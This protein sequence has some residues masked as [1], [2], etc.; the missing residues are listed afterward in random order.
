V[1]I[2]A[3]S[4]LV[5][6]AGRRGCGVRFVQPRQAA[7]GLYASHMR[8][9]L[10]ADSLFALQERAML[11]RLELGLADDGVSVV[12]ALPEQLLAR[13]ASDVFARS[14]PYTPVS[15]PLLRNFATRSLAERV[16]KLDAD[17]G[18]GQHV[19]V[20]HAFGG[21]IW[22]VA[23]RLAR[24]IGAG[25]ALD[26]WRSGLVSRVREL[27]LQASDDVVLIAPDAKTQQRLR[28]QP[29]AV[30]NLPCVVA[31]WGVLAD[32]PHPVLEA[33]R[34]A[35]IMLVG[36][37]RDS[38]AFHAVIAGLAPMLRQ[39]DDVLVFCDARAARRADLWRYAR[40]IDK[41]LVV[42]SRISLV[43]DLEARPDLLLAGDLLLHPEASGEQRSMLLEAFGRGVVVVAANDPNVDF[44]ISGTTAQL[45][46]QP[47]E[48]GAWAS[49]V[50]ELLSHPA[51][52]A[53]L[54]AT[55]NAYVRTHRKA[56]EQVR[57]VLEAYTK[58]RATQPA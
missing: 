20:V 37:G 15:A 44:L 8:A 17:E 39:R 24:Q 38:A 58:L 35:S 50:G 23:L 7:W 13:S 18:E 19:R 11:S 40:S 36:T 16:A 29:G 47:R 48:P 27:S 56:S 14:L 25:L 1:P 9:L 28:E 55:A 4:E 51:K 21:S 22:P 32:T 31:P 49:A 12:Q 5:G 42:R 41:D 43:E 54:A 52:A 45:V 46:M 33:K 2:I 57:G 10:I 26:V 34:S 30:K 6:E 3:A 53:A